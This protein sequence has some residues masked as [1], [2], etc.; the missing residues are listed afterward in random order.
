[1]AMVD[2]Y[3]YIQSPS[4]EE[5]SQNICNTEAARSSFLTLA[6]SGEAM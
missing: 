5:A 6:I 4:Q 1:M 3:T 2:D